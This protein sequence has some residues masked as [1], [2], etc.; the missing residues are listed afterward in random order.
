MKSMTS[1]DPYLRTSVIRQKQRSLRDR[2]IEAIRNDEV[3]EVVVK[4]GLISEAPLGASENTIESLRL[5]HAAC[6]RLCTAGTL[7][8]T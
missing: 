1:A 2:V 6:Q 7:E 4:S 5:S 8:G 3:T